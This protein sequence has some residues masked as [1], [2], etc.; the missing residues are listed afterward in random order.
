MPV[1]RTVCQACHSECGVLAHVEGGRVVRLQGDPDHPSNK[2]FICTKGKNEIGRLYHP[3]RLL[4]PLKRVGARGEV[5]W[6]RVTWDEALNG[7]AQGLTAVKDSYGAEAICGMRGTGPRAG[8]VASLVPCALGSPNAISSDLHI[9]FAPSIIGENVTIGTSTLMERG[10]DHE[11]SAC[12]LV[13]GSNPMVA[14]PPRGR[15][16]LRGRINNG[17]KLIV[18]DPRRTYLASKADLWLRIRPGSDAALVLGMMDVIIKE[19]LYDRD[20]V[21][22][23]CLGFDALAAR[24]AAYPVEKVAEISWLPA[25]QIREAAR[26]YATTKP[27]VLHHRVAMDQSL[28]STRCSQAMIQLVAITGNLDVPGGNLMPP[29]IAGYYPAGILSGGGPCAPPP[30]VEEKRLGAARF[31]LISSPRGRF[32]K[33]FTLMFVHPHLAME[34]M[35]GRGEY[36]LKAMYCSAGNPLLTTMD[37]RRFRDALLDLEL[38]VV[39]DFFMTPTAELADYVLPAAT[40]LERDDLCDDG[41]TDYIAARQKAVEPLG[42]ARHDLDIVIDLISRI[43]WADRARLPWKSAAEC[44]DWMLAGMGLTFAELARQGF[45]QEPRRYKKYEQAGFD[46]ASGKVELTASRFTGLGYDPLPFYVEP[47]ESPLSTPEL[48]PEYPFVLI[49]GARRIEYMTSEGRQ[50][51][52]LRKQRPHPQVEIHPAAAA[53]VGLVEGEWAWLETPRKPGEKIRLKIKYS[54]GLDPRVVSADYGW[55]FPE[56]P[57]PE[58]G[59]FESNINVVTDMGP[60]WEEICGSV[61]LRGTLC[62]LRAGA[63][64][65]VS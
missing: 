57:G 6:E 18:V 47:S 21:E 43:P 39:A 5:R 59:C 44:N 29:R 13:F 11:N 10:P 17:A 27:A 30:E 4:Y 32:C 14:H 35:E 50:V 25:E 28:C 64:A 62:R 52:G 7:I 38:L 46:T 65:P 61:P 16:V 58:H 56:L 40:W 36:P 49:T 23:W 54:A 3:D 1:I 63:E 45:Y 19:G 8:G 42:E 48:L 12:I 55:W 53:A 41:Y 60:P 26:L 9:C 51:P 31:P 2:G 15:D 20:F 34:A 24:A 37:V 22:Q 33:G